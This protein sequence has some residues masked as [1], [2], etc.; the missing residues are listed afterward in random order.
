MTIAKQACELLERLRG[1]DML[2][3]SADGAYWRAEIDKVLGPRVPEPMLKNAELARR[4][5]VKHPHE[6]DP[7]DEPDYDF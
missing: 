3:A 2:D 4:L 6:F 7:N 5:F 1:W